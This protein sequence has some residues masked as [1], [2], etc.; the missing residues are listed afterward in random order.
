[1]NIEDLTIKQAKELA[2]LFSGEATKVAADVATEMLG[3]YVL[4]RTYSA[5]VWAGTLS[6]KSGNEVI[7]K[8]AR[9][10]WAWTAKEGISLSAVA[11]F[12]IDESSSRIAGPV[13]MVWLEAIEIIPFAGSAGMTV[14]GAKN[15]EAR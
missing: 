11:V 13:P 1:M 14:S 12:G 10:L 3:Q 4:V 5:G 9:R 6:K 8:D 15:A 7:L 2:Q